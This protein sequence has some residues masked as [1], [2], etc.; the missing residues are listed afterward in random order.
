MLEDRMLLFLLLF[1]KYWVFC[2]LQNAS[3]PFGECCRLERNQREY[4]ADDTR[5]IEAPIIEEMTRDLI[6]LSA[7]L[8]RSRS[9][10]ETRRGPFVKA[11]HPLR[12]QEA[13]ARV[14]SYSIEEN[15][16]W[17]GCFRAVDEIGVFSRH[18][19]LP[20]THTHTPTPRPCTN[21]HPQNHES[22]QIEAYISK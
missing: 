10:K 22:L 7:F 21:Y 3:E 14:L 12:V 8:V 19:Y 2:E 15:I 17:G 13:A 5:R 18:S 11:L 4:R 20:T 1:M 9:I 16:F 6:L